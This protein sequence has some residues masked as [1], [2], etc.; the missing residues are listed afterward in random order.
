MK[1]F[2]EHDAAG[3]IHTVFVATG[4]SSTTVLQPGNGRQVSA[5][6]AEFVGHPRDFANLRN[7]RR[8]YQVEG[9]PSRATLVKISA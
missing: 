5:V 3:K 9:H 2:V 1:I 6:E 7:V 4:S 8:E